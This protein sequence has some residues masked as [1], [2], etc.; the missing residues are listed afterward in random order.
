M[1]MKHVDRTAFTIMLAAA[2]TVAACSTSNSQSSPEPSSHF[3]RLP[4][5][6]CIDVSRGVDWESA[7]HEY[8]LEAD[9]QRAVPSAEEGRYVL[10]VLLRGDFHSD[11]PECAGYLL[12]GEVSA[13]AA[14]LHSTLYRY[15]LDPIG[16]SPNL[17][18]AEAWKVLADACPDE[19]D[20]PSVKRLDRLHPE[21][22]SPVLEGEP[23]YWP[24][25]FEG[26]I[27]WQVDFEEDCR[28]GFEAGLDLTLAP[29][30]DAMEYH[31]S[32]YTLAAFDLKGERANEP[33]SAIE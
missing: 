22:V 3:A 33:V 31:T 28:L 15:S 19:H 5:V 29:L 13:N 12:P 24:S 11:A 18:A 20:A 32:E 14:W 27:S 26:W 7:A 21:A 1:G 17:S 8:D 4:E 9:D 2:A 6:P 30:S 16:A 10:S 23:Q 25:P